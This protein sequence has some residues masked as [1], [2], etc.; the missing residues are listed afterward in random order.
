MK[1]S[2]LA[3]VAT[4]GL[5]L[6]GCSVMHFQNGAVE[7]TGRMHESWHHNVAYSL[8]EISKPLDMKTLC[9]DQGGKWSMITT[10]ETFI[11]GLAGQADEALTG[12]LLK[13][14]GGID[15]WDPQ[16]VEYTCGK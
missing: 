14:A 4:A 6:S 7:P 11:T 12:A 5:V 10:K 2:F 16:M 9:A 3:A 8:L 15:L 1:A 13:S